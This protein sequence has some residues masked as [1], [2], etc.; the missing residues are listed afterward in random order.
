MKNQVGK[1]FLLIALGMLILCLIFGLL[2]AFNYIFPGIWKNSLSFT[3]LRP[4]HVSS[5]LFW[6]LSGS[7]GTIYCTLGANNEKGASRRL[8]V[9][10]LLFWITGI[11]GMFYAYLTNQFGGREYWEFN[12]IFAFPIAFAWLLFLIQFIRMVKPIAQWPVYI[13]MWLT[14][15]IFFFFTFIENYLWLF[16]YFRSNF[17]TDTTI[18]WKV[19]GAMVGSWNQLIYGIAFYIMERISGDTKPARSKKAFL[20]YFLGLFNLMFNWGHHIY[21]LPTDTYVRDLGY[22]VSMTEWILLANIIY[23]W[24]RSL[25]QI[26]KNY[27]FFSYRFLMAADIW[28]FIS[29]IQALLMSVPILNLYTH[30]THVTVAH[31][32]GTTIGINSMILFAVFVFF[33]D[34]SCYTIV[35]IFRKWMNILYWLTQICLFVFWITLN[36]IGIKKGI[37]QLHH[38]EISFYNMMT[39][40]QLLF[41]IFTY[42]GSLLMIS[43]ISIAV[44]IGFK[45]LNCKIN[46]LGKLNENFIIVSNNSKS[47]KS[48]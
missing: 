48:T 30:G 25:K 47:F 31:A 28:I 43:M 14:G 29:L 2:A 39:D 13:W 35:G 18:Q 11:V 38:P 16:P 17:I 40:M 12:P 3:K 37:L 36:V 20:M 9:L 41:K 6:I 27:T 4:L 15:I 21:T 26:Q 1:L 42:T 34:N 5:A 32:M 7:I 24:R 10:H 23:N 44:M 22:A 45:Y 8:S 19:N 33:L 46:K